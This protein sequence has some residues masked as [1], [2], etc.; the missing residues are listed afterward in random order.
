MSFDELADTADDV[1]TELIAQG[2]AEQEEEFWK[3]RGGTEFTS[4]AGPVNAT[5]IANFAAIVRA[6]GKDRAAF[7]T[8]FQKCVSGEMKRI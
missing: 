4:C 3:L 8:F 6:L 5:A 7:D 1:T 2:T